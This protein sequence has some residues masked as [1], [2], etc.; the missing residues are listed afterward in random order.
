MG[1][2]QRRELEAHPVLRLFLRTRRMEMERSEWAGVTV[3]MEPAER[4]RISV[5]KNRALLRLLLALHEQ[6]GFTACATRSTAATSRRAKRR[7]W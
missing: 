4:A 3:D 6:A 7:T 2:A 5:V 1:A